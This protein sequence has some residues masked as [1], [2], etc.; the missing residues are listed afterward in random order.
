[1]RDR[2]ITDSERLNHILAAISAIAEFT[3]E[4]SRNDFLGDRK[5]IDATL[6]QFA[7]IGE[8]IIHVSEEILD[9][10]DFPWYKVRALRNFILHE[11]H[12]IEDTVIWETINKDLPRL[13]QIITLI[14]KNEFNI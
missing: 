14:L 10:Y 12:A 11:Y 8:A 6:F 13:K 2:R 7:V 1:M 9:K 5:T 3:G 4:S